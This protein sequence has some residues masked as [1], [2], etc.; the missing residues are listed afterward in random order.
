MYLD[1]KALKTSSASRAHA[2]ELLERR[3]YAVN[4]EKGFEKFGSGDAFPMTGE[5]YAELD[6]VTKS[7]LTEPTSMTLFSDLLPLSKSVDIGEL[8][9]ES[10]RSGDAG[11]ITVD[12]SIT[13]AVP[14]DK[15]QYNYERTVVPVFRGGVERQYRELASF[16]R[17]GIDALM[18]DYENEVRFIKNRIGNYFLYGDPD[19]NFK[20]VQGYGLLNHHGVKEYNTKVDMTSDKTSGE[21]IRNALLSATSQARK[22]S[23][24]VEPRTLYISL[25]VDSQL[26]RKYIPTDA[27]SKSIRE[28]LLSLP[29]IKDIKP[30]SALEGNDM[31]FGVLSS[32]YI[33]P[34]VG[35]EISSFAMPRFTPYSP[36]EMIIWGAVGLDIRNDFNGRGGWAVITK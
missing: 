32:Q 1:Q 19:A 17:K 35:Q 11:A 23:L 6:A 7:I 10:R 2:K 8:I 14:V 30:C 24:V 18:D 33:R 29:L 16:K 12:M 34:I 28:E 26:D 20:G 5:M 27:A 15:T 22:D 9:H 3:S 36:F 31:I 21:S 25:D 13:T 4:S